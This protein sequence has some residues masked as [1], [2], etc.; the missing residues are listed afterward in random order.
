[1]S[2]A[3]IFSFFFRFVGH[4]V[5]YSCWFKF[6]SRINL[7]MGQLFRGDNLLITLHWYTIIQIM[8]VHCLVL[9]FQFMAKKSALGYRSFGSC[10][11]LHYFVQSRFR[12]NLMFH[13]TELK[14]SYLPNTS[15][16]NF[17]HTFLPI[18]FLNMSKLPLHFYL[19]KYYVQIKNQKRI[20]VFKKKNEV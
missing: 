15:H 13:L 7:G 12:D 18:S 17:L 4:Q 2:P 6:M 14:L 8:W 5:C 1:M 16:E 10:S 11:T 3:C 19:K 9:R 20:I